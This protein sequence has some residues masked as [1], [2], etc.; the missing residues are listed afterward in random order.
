MLAVARLTRNAQN[1]RIL[2]RGCLDGVALL[3]MHAARCVLARQG[4]KKPHNKG[5]I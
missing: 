2:M 1:I 4:A 5:E 3:S